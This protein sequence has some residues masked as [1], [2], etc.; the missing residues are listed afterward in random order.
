MARKAGAGWRDGNAE[1]GSSLA[2][3]L[4][5]MREELLWSLTVNS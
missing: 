4:R 5:W 1:Q 2:G 3:F